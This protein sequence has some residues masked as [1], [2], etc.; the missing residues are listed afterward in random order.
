MAD[1]MLTETQRREIEHVS[2]S[3]EDL[4]LEA[5]QSLFPDNVIKRLLASDRAR[6]KALWTVAAQLSRTE[7]RAEIAEQ[8]VERLTTTMRSMI[9]DHNAERKNMADEM[10]ALRR[11]KLATDSEAAK[12]A[13]RIDAIEVMLK[14]QPTIEAL[15]SGLNVMT[16]QAAALLVRAERSERRCVELEV[17]LE[18]ILFR[19]RVLEE[20]SSDD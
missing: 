2:L 12:L 15:R 1:T 6:D 13:A 17:K 18:Q 7:D 9:A 19:D 11:D 14:K 5:D 20:L 4:D 3:P 8:E 16:D 10:V